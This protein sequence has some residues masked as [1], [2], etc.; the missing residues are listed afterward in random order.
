MSSHL[1]LIQDRL[2]ELRRWKKRKEEQSVVH[3]NSLI[4]A[5]A[6]VDVFEHAEVSSDA[7]P[8]R[9]RSKTKSKRMNRKKREREELIR[10]LEENEDE[11]GLGDMDHHVV[12]TIEDK[13][14]QE[15]DLQ[16]GE[17]D[18]PTDHSSSVSLAISSTRA[19]ESNKTTLPN[20]PTSSL[21]PKHYC[22]SPTAHQDS[23]SEEASLYSND[24]G[25]NVQRKK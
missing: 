13:E 7:I 18:I 11:E 14:E 15:Q 24:A 4:R 19:S 5:N 25:T 6:E 9:S 16:G 2:D 17:P 8:S 3:D 1:G 23:L 10:N 22:S 21:S 12:I 20:E